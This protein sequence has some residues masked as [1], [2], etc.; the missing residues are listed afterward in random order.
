MPVMVLQSTLNP[1]AFVDNTQHPYMRDIFNQKHGC[2]AQASGVGYVFTYEIDW[3]RNLS[4]NIA[5][6][7]YPTHFTYNFLNDGDPE[8]GSLV[9]HGWDI[10]KEN[11]CPSVATYGGMCVNNDPTYWMTGYEKYHS[12]LYNTIDFYETINFGDDAELGLDLLKQWIYDHN[13]EEAY[14]GLASFMTNMQACHYAT[15]PPGLPEENK[16]LVN[17]WS[18]PSGD[19]HQLTFVGYN[20]DIHFDYNNDGLYTDTIDI[21]D[22]G[23]VDMQDWEW[24]ALKVANSWGEDWPYPIDSGYV[25]WPYK[26]LAQPE[27]ISGY[28]AHVVHVLEDYEPEVTIKIKMTH[29]VRSKLRIGVDFG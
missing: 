14:G 24:G 28:I 29:P 5:D 27:V 11:G 15:I 26:L 18:N 4:A 17:E 22:D 2:C 9:Y 23:V 12:A 7:L 20:D 21:N 13:A 1:P 8:E 25:Y 16:H 3:K 19:N 10:I 6:N